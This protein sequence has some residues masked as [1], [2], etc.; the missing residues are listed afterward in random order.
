MFQS[1]GDLIADRRYAYAEGAARDGDWRTAA[2]VLEQALERSP[3]WAPAWLALGEARER[4]AETEAAA[5]AYRTALVFDP[6][7]TLG[8][9]ARLV[10]LGALSP[11]QLPAAY[12]RSLFDDYAPRYEK[13]LIE[14]LAYRGPDLILEALDTV[15]P[16]RRFDQALDL[17]CGDGM[18]G[19]KIRPRA[20]TLLGVD[21]SP[22]MV[23][24]ARE[25]GVYDQVETNDI[26]AFLEARAAG[27]AD[28]LLA[29]DALPYLGD[30]NSFFAAAARALAPRGLIAFTTEAIDGESYRLIETLRFAHS[31]LFLR[32]CAESAGFDVRRLESGVA[33]QENGRDAPGWIGVLERFD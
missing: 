19:A 17:G 6:T 18:M 14:G 8:A 12:I 15:A 25:R 28:L 31:R 13:H 26:C 21:L 23:A 2:E 32:R 29:A 27:A 24:K 11:R 7:D 4:L 30:L 20:D 10:R 9:T 22:A 33:R 5:D 3:D 16:G 1:S